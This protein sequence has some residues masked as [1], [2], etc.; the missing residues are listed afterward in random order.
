MFMVGFFFNNNN[1]NNICFG[2]FYGS[3][4]V[5]VGFLNM[6]KCVFNSDGIFIFS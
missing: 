4:Y 2:G 6:Y 1:Y 3:N 5:I